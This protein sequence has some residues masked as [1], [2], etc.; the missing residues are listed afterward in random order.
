MTTNTKKAAPALTTKEEQTQ[1]PVAIE[2]KDIKAAV[3][4]LSNFFI[5]LS[6]YLHNN[7][8]TLSLP[9]KDGVSPKI[10]DYVKHLGMTPEHGEGASLLHI[11]NRSLSQLAP[12]ASI[13]AIVNDVLPTWQKGVILKSHIYKAPTIASSG[14]KNAGKAKIDREG[15]LV[16]MREIASDDE[17]AE[18]SKVFTLADLG[19]KLYFEKTSTIADSLVSRAIAHIKLK[20]AEAAGKEEADALAVLESLGLL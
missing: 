10:E 19:F 20:D 6:S 17:H 13:A 12:N 5:G 4:S 14:G 11:A 7:L 1:T 15:V 3:V 8:D 2:T 18:V 9:Y 16:A